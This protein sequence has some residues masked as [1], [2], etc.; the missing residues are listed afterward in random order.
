MSYQLTSSASSDKWGHHRISLLLMRL[1][2]QRF[3]HTME[4]PLLGC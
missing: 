4:C 2:S 3:L 1:L